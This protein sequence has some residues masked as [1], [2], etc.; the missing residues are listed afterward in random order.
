MLLIQFLFAESNHLSS[1]SFPSPYQWVVIK[2]NEHFKYVPHVGATQL[3]R[4]VEQL[5]QSSGE[6][7]N[8]CK[9]KFQRSLL[10]KSRNCLQHSLLTI[11]SLSIV[12]IT[13][14]V[15][16]NPTIFVVSVACLFWGF[17]LFVRFLAFV[18]CPAPAMSWNNQFCSRCW[19][20]CDD[21]S[22]SKLAC[23]QTLISVKV[24]SG[25]F[26]CILLPMQTISQTFLFGNK[27]YSFLESTCP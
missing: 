16:C 11:L 6:M 14:M 2:L 27:T 19:L 22:S 20:I 5:I 24:N 1:I 4:T 15:I 8:T 25:E 21:E 12:K 18:F 26:K 13:K 10:G 3:I 7:E 9:S 17:C 23:Q